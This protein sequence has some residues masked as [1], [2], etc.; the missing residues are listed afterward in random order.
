[1]LEELSAQFK[2]VGHVNI[3]DQ[4]D[5]NNKQVLLDKDNAVHPQNLARIIARGLAHEPNAWVWTMNLGNGGT[6]I[7]SSQQISYL[8]PITTG[9]G[10]TLYNQTYSEQIDETDANTPVNNSCVSAASPAPAITSVVTCVMELDAT[11]PNTQPATDGSITT[12]PDD[13][14]AFDE[15][16]LKSQDGLMLSHIIFNPIQKSANRSLLITYTLT[17]SVAAS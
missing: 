17:I 7:N 15:M 12:N 11:E 16:C 5:P 4:T 10:A 8:S 9:V 1:M 3:V 14:Y 6:H 13:V 2:V